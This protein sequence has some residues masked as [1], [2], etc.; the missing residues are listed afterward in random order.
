MTRKDLALPRHRLFGRCRLRKLS[1]LPVACAGER[2]RAAVR[3][4]PRRNSPR[5][6]WE[7]ES[8]S[9]LKAHRE[10]P[11]DPHRGSTLSPVKPDRDHPLN[12]LKPHRQQP[13]DALDPPQTSQGSSPHFPQTTQ[14]IISSTPKKLIGDQPLKPYRISPSTPSGGAAPQT[15]Q[16]TVVLLKKSS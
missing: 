12:A 13:L 5:L 16:G 4:G 15:S 2:G 1:A 6:L 10:Q 14:G 11:H 3:W 7:D 8:R 9:T